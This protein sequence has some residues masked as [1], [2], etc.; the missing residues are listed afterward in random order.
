MLTH[1]SK[2]LL[3]IEFIYAK[4][5]EILYIYMIISNKTNLKKIFN[6]SNIVRLS[7]FMC[8]KEIL[9]CPL[10]KTAS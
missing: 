5:R 4:D 9:R 3:S 7:I 10:P 6:H 8:F 1:H 2:E